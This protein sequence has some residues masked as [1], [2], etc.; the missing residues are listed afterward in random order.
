MPEMNLIAVVVAA[1][2]AFLL[3]GLWYGPLFGQRWLAACGQME[4]VLNGRSMAQVFGLAG[5][6]SLIAALNLAA[7][8]GPDAD[9]EFGVFAGFAAGAGW[10]GAFLGIIYLFEARPLSL[11]LI[12]AG[13]STAA[14]T[15]MGAILGG[16]R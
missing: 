16:W 3:G 12:N 5:A 15:I 7:F 4:D 9:L 6:L 8:L 13:Y 10:V 1:L 14:L 2:S 11:W